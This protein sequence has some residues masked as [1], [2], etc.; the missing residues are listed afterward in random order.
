MFPVLLVLS[1]IA[2]PNNFFFFTLLLQLLPLAAPCGLPT[3]APALMW[4][5]RQVKSHGG[6]FAKSL[7]M[8]HDLQ[9]PIKEQEE[10]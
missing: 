8:L 9:S 3:S 2:K 10:F 4:G 6:N 5:R 1:L 7:L